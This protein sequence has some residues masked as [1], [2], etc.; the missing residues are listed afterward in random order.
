MIFHE[1]VLGSFVT[2]ARITEAKTDMKVELHRD[3][4]EVLLVFQLDRGRKG[5]F[6]I[7]RQGQY[8][9]RLCDGLVL[10]RRTGGIKMLLCLV[11]LKGS[12][13]VDAALQIKETL[14]E[15]RRLV[16]KECVCGGP[17]DIAWAAFIASNRPDHPKHTE[18]Q[19][20][21]NAHF[22]DRFDILRPEK[23]EQWLRQLYSRL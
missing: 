15:L 16:G 20:L 13:L 21:L 7:H 10:F 1:R 19:K 17:L 18:A 23:F 11:E 12:D 6:R 14:V 4:T 9:G 22:Q 5:P 8:T 3:P 2:E